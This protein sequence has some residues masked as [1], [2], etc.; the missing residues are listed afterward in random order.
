MMTRL[1]WLVRVLRAFRDSMDSGKMPGTPHTLVG[2]PKPGGFDGRYMPFVWPGPDI[3]DWTDGSEGH[4][5]PIVTGMVIKDDPGD[6]H[7]TELEHGILAYDPMRLALAADIENPSS[8]FAHA[9]EGVVFP[10]SADEAGGLTPTDGRDFDRTLVI[11][12]R[13]IV[14][15][16]V[17]KPG[18]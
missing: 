16:C 17:E 3:M 1:P 12:E 11:G 15:G 4:R 9:F 2:W 10:A 13:W 18:A 5:V 6:K 7:L 8:A 14:T